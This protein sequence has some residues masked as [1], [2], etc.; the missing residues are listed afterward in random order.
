MMKK[1]V[2][3]GNTGAREKNTWVDEP[4]SGAAALDDD[5]DP[6]IDTGTVC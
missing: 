2:W 3:R 1:G 6:S 4:P 5:D